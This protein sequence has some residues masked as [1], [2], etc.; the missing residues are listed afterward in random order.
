MARRGYAQVA[1][2]IRLANQYLTWL[3]SS[4]FA[5]LICFNKGILLAV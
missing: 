3:D 4:V 5:E 1:P 2:E